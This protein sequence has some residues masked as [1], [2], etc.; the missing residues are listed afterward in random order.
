[1]REIIPHERTLKFN[2]MEYALPREGG[3]DC[4][5]AVRA[6]V[7]E[8]HRRE[9]AWRV[10]YRTVAAEDAYLSPSF[11]RDTTT[12]SVHQNAHLPFREFFADI[13]PIF[14]DF[15][16]RPHWAK[17]NTLAPREVA[18]LYPRWSDFCAL[19]QRLDPDGVFLNEYL[20]RLLG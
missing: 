12:I 2:E 3:P 7:L 13:E 8:R 20:R 14:R 11:G 16:G 9:V 1:M 17:L 5:G 15:G 4:F 6:R 10:L 19:R 18:A